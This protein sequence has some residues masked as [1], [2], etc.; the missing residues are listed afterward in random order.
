MIK[1]EEKEQKIVIQWADLMANK[2]PCLRWLYAIPNGGSRNRIEAVNLKRSGVKS[3]VSDLCLPYAN[4]KFHG[5]YIEMK[6]GKNKPSAN[7]KEF[8]EYINNSGYLGIVCYSA[9]EAITQIERYLK[10][11]CAKK[12]GHITK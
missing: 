11:K 12:N 1:H 5:L 7:Q 4:N 9:E 6:H 8:L 10:I 2:Y 3:G